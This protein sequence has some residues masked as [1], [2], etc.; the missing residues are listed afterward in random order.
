MKERSVAVA[1]MSKTE[2]AVKNGDFLL[3]FLLLLSCGNPFVGYYLEKYIYIVFLVLIYIL[4]RPHFTTS[5]KKTLYRWFGLLIVIFA[6]QLI[7]LHYISYLASLNF[8]VK[9]ACGFCV[10]IALGTRFKTTYLSVMTVVCV[11]SLFFFALQVLGLDLPNLMPDGDRRS[12]GIYTISTPE[13]YDNYRLR[14]AGMFWEQGAFAGYINIAFILFINNLNDLFRKHTRKVVVLLTA[15][16]T[17][18]STTGYI[19]LALVIVYHIMASKTNGVIKTFLLIA[20]VALAVLAFTRFDFLGEKITTQFAD[21]SDLTYDSNEHSRFGSMVSD[22]FYI[23]LHPIFGN[24][25]AIETRYAYHLQFYDVETLMG[26][27]NG[28][29]GIIGTLGIP[30]MLYY[31]YSFYKNRTLNQWLFII[32]FIVLSLQGEQFMNYPLFL[33]LPFVNYGGFRNAKKTIIINLGKRMKGNA[34]HP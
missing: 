11:I 26:F 10:A 33:M 2:K 24:G 6:G 22:W 16:L 30:F 32:L 1:N 19:I 23:T 3:V 25:F 4:N 5:D 20:S 13:A 12:I 15:L 28:F 31:L 29:T 8:M 14:N 27:G 21:A 34:V 9:L 18:F 7:T 17:T